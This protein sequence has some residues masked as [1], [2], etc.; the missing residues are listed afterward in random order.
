MHWGVISGSMTGLR[1]APWCMRVGG[2]CAYYMIS[3]LKNI[4]LAL[5]IPASC[6][7]IIKVY[8][9]ID[10]EPSQKF[11]FCLVSKLNTAPLRTGAP[12]K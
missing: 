5:W 7:C 11:L 9:S 4:R 12:L 10:G 8:I 1:I 2:E 6:T 3:M